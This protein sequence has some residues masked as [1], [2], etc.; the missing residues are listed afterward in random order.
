MNV[1]VFNVCMHLFSCEQAAAICKPWL[2]AAAKERNRAPLYWHCLVWIIGEMLHPIRIQ[3]VLKRQQLESWTE[4]KEKWED[5]NVS[6][7][8]V[9]EVKGNF[10]SADNSLDKAVVKVKR[11]ETDNYFKLRTHLKE[12][13]AGP[14]ASLV[15]CYLTTPLL[16]IFTADWFTTAP[17]N[18][19]WTVMKHVFVPVNKMSGRTCEVVAKQSKPVLQTRFWGYNK[20]YDIQGQAK[21]LYLWYKVRFHSITCHEGT[22]CNATPSLTWALEGVGG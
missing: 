22:R 12:I 19:R 10:L 18:N 15:C 9:W 1:S 6:G 5:G 20:V 2:A 14:Y 13:N 3:S 17:S 4:K 11:K 16:F 8:W 21:Y 7:L